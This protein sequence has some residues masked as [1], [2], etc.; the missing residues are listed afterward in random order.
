MHQ[1]LIK[2]STRNILLLIM[3]VVLGS[4]A[5]TRYKYS[6]ASIPQTVT[7]LKSLEGYY[8]NCPFDDTGSSKWNVPLWLLAANRDPQRQRKGE[9][10][11]SYN[12]RQRDVYVKGNYQVQLEVMSERKLRARLYYKGS[13]LGKP[14]I[15]RGRV[16]NGCFRRRKLIVYPLFPLLY[17]YDAETSEIYLTDQGIIVAEKAKNWGAFIGFGG[18]HNSLVHRE[19]MRLK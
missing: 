13:A 4:C 15:I 17:G 6:G 8:E 12:Q 2:V 10:S 14:R 18:S 7:N 16:K 19:Y 1:N 5:K 11:A 9:D 3:M